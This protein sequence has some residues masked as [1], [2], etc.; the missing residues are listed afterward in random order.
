MGG[1]RRSRDLD[2]DGLD[3]AAGIGQPHL[4]GELPKRFGAGL[5][6]LVGAG[7]FQSVEKSRV[8]SDVGVV[9][10]VVDQVFERGR[11]M[12]VVRALAPVDL[13][14]TVT[15]TSAFTASVWSNTRSP[16][17]ER[18]A[19]GTGQVIERRNRCPAPLGNQGD[20]GAV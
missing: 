9:E 10:L 13:Q 2:A 17:R 20:H 5:L 15:S 18:E 8:G 12:E 19:H 7:L 16:S 4:L 14:A 3:V 6:E 11:I 1:A